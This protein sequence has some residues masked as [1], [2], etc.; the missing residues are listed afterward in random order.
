MRN[1]QSITSSDEKTATAYLKKNNWNFE[2]AMDNYY[3]EGAPGFVE[4]PRTEQTSTRDLERAFAPYASR[5]G[6]VMGPEQIER[7]CSDLGIDVMDPVILI[8]AKYFRAE[9]MEDFKKQEFMQGMAAMGVDTIAKLKAKIPQLRNELKDNRAFKDLYLFVFGFS[10]DKGSRN[11]SLETAIGL[12]RLLLVPKYSMAEDWIRFLE[13]RERKHDISRDT[14]NMALD[15]F[16]MTKTR[17]V[18]DYQDDGAWP[19][20]VDEFVEFMRS[21]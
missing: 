4:P 13:T 5:E 20:I 2:Q 19:V 11:I 17:G 10:R 12:W 18:A 1:F 8:I 6:D 9:C 14:W 7:F 15:F 21:Q 3:N 16:E